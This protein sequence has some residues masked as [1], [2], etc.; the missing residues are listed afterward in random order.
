MWTRTQPV[1]ANNSLR[2]HE[3]G[4]GWEV[5]GGREKES[6]CVR[7]DAIVSARTL[8]F[9]RADATRMRANALDPRGHNSRPCGR[10]PTSARMRRLPLR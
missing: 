8:G 7:A 3:A 2:P 1:R 10:M 6:E 9:V 4:E 5:G